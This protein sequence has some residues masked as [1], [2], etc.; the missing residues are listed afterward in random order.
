MNL[1]VSAVAIACG[2]LIAAS[3]ARAVR[4]W[5]WDDVEKLTPHKRA[6]YFLGFRIMGIAIGLTG[7]LFAVDSIWFP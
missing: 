4:Y 3:P 5:G 6:L 1:F 2:A 7:I